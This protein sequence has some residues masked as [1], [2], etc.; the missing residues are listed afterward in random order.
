[1]K[2]QQNETAD[3]LIAR[4]H[5]KLAQCD[6]NHITDMRDYLGMVGIMV[7][8]EPSLQKRMFLDKVDTFAKAAAAVKADAQA[9]SHSKMTPADQ[10]NINATSSYKKEQNHERSRPNQGPYQS[11]PSSGRGQA[12]GHDHPRGQGGYHSSS[13]RDQERGRSQDRSQSHNRYESRIRNCHRCG[14]TNHDQQDCYFKDKPC[15]N[16]DRIGHI[17]TVCRIPKRNNSQSGQ[18]QAS[19]FANSVEGHLST[20]F[21]PGK[22]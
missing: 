9:T 16:C 6:T 3:H 13:S 2:R 10:A 5:E 1:M 14:K 19:G 7:A 22:L 18:G 12:R 15:L 17:S 21:D 11:Q 8:C 20:M 4:V